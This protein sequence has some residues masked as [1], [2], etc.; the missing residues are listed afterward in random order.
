MSIHMG[1][2]YRDYAWGQQNGLGLSKVDLTTATVAVPNL[3]AAELLRP[4]PRPKVTLSSRVISQPPCDRLIILDCSH[5]GRSI[6][7][8]LLE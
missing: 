7:L 8:S 3:S 6:I 2:K 1:H 5:H 4:T